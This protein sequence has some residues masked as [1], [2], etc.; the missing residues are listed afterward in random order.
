[1][2]AWARNKRCIF[3]V[4]IRLPD[5][6]HGQLQRQTED[7]QCRGTQSTHR[8]R[9][10][11]SHGWAPGH[12]VSFTQAHAISDRYATPTGCGEKESEA[13][14]HPHLAVPAPSR[15]THGSHLYPAT[16]SISHL[17][18]L[19]TPVVSNSTRWPPHTHCRR[20]V[21][22]VLCRSHPSLGSTRG[23]A[24]SR[25]RS[26]AISKSSGQ[27]HPKMARDRNPR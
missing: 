8:R 16:D 7:I 14:P 1:M 25:H 6:R 15:S 13:I 18:G 3:T 21:N 22:L 23:K 4:L 9:R 11:W 20:T 26:Q 24:R 2:L 17:T 12:Q 27:C 10:A 19:K 5:V